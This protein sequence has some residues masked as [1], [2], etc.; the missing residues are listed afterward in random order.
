MAAKIGL[1]PGGNTTTLIMNA[2]QLLA[3]N[4]V[5]YTIFLRRLCDFDSAIDASNTPLR[6]CFNDR[7][8]FD[9][10]AS[11]YAAALRQQ[12]SSATTRHQAMRTVNPKY[13][14]RSHLAEIAR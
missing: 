9:A 13:I 14:L 4:R 11:R 3:Q 10:W 6:D 12:G 2:L 7:A 5:D 1:P 8:A